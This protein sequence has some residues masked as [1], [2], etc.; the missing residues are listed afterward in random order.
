M[1]TA[2]PTLPDPTLSLSRAIIAS[3]AAPMLLLDSDLTV[4]A[5]SGSFCQ[6]FHLGP[7][8]VEGR[9]LL[10]L[11]AG[12]WNVRQLEVLLSA[13]ADGAAEVDA[14]EMELKAAGAPPR[15]LVV[16]A[17]KLDYGAGEAVRLLVSVA[18]VTDARAASLLKDQLLENKAVLLRELQHR[19]ANSLQIIASVLLQSA[20]KAG[21]G[22]TKAVLS[23]AHNRVMSVAALQRQLAA[24]TVSQVALKGYFT[25][26]C[27]SIGASMIRDHSLLTLS[28]DADNA[29][30]D[31]DTSISLGLII[32]ELV[33]NALKHAFPANQKGLMTVGYHVKDGAWT[34]SVDD[35][36]V[37]MPADP[38]DAVAG[39]GTS[40]VQALAKQLGANVTVSSNHPGTRVSIHHAAIPTADEMPVLQAV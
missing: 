34:L 14:Y 1:T 31:P 4:V 32:T 36:G 23:D 6:A 15:T 29:K 11:G 7:D 8:A 24:S 37:G 12:E 33:I 20:R 22:E 16:S 21:A 9:S 10:S 19:V 2:R 28:V 3:S 40:I 35:N 25:Q 17:R 38:A 13:T 5:A 27:A 30:V 39:L 26:L 18:D